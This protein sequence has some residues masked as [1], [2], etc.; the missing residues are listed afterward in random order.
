VGWF[1]AHGEIAEREGVRVGGARDDA[2]GDQLRLVRIGDDDR[3]VEAPEDMIGRMVVVRVVPVDAGARDD[4]VVEIGPARGYL[5]LGQR[6]AVA[7]VGQLDAVPVD[8]GGFRVE[9][10]LEVDDHPLADGEG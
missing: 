1:L 7:G 2:V 4:E 8:A 10:V 5:V 3:A 6:C 9:V